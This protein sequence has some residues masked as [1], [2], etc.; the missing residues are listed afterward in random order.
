METTE[1]FLNTIAVPYSELFLVNKL[2]T[3]S[4]L[5]LLAKSTDDVKVQ[6]NYL[7]DIEKIFP[8]IKTTAHRL[9]VYE[10]ANPSYSADYVFNLNNKILEEMTNIISNV[11]LLMFDL[12]EKATEKGDDDNLPLLT[13]FRYEWGISLGVESERFNVVTRLQEKGYF[14]DK[15]YHGVVM[16]LNKEDTKQRL[17]LLEDQLIKL[18]T[19]DALV[20]KLES[21]RVLDLYTSLQKVQSIYEKTDGLGTDASS[22][23]IRKGYL[24]ELYVNLNKYA[25]SQLNVSGDS[26]IKTVVYLSIQSLLNY[27]AEGRNKAENVFNSP[28]DINFDAY[29]FF[30]GDFQ[31]ITNLIRERMSDLDSYLI[32]N[33]KILG[34]EYAELDGGDY[35]NT[36]LAKKVNIVRNM[37]SSYATSIGLL[38]GNTVKDVMR[39]ILFQYVESLLVFHC[40]KTNRK[41]SEGVEVTSVDSYEQFVML[42]ILYTIMESL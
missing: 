30:E 40:S 11:N 23:K 12:I 25:N 6:I 31:K 2:A 20:L 35:I 18:D 38:E 14:I 37:L 5:Y 41:I 39:G 36:E 34:D 29:K 21:K 17:R 13:Y 15:T 8:R 9:K 28:D 26:L 33:Y 42:G 3:V 32:G 1:D 10:Y 22:Q 7:F 4:N 24:N 19:Q 27:L 16:V